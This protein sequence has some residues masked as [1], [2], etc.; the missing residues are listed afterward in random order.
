MGIA[1]LSADAMKT[2]QHELDEALFEL[3]QRLQEM[4]LDIEV[5]NGGIDPSTGQADLF[6]LDA[7]CEDDEAN[8]RN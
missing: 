8:W 6:V 1:K 4:N 7:D 3:S 2:V 5:A